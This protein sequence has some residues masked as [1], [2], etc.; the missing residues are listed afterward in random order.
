MCGI[1]P[2]K[3]ERKQRSVLTHLPRINNV[4]NVP[5]KGFASLHWHCA[6]KQRGKKNVMRM[7]WG[8]TQSCTKAV[9]MKFKKLIIYASY[10]K[11]PPSPLVPYYENQVAYMHPTQPQ[12]SL[13]VNHIHWFLLLLQPSKLHMPQYGWE[14]SCVR[15]YTDC[16]CV[17]SCTC[18]GRRGLVA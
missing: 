6:Y 8:R 10:L 5:Q 9:Y 3:V 16:V 1:E 2:Y 12:W 17:R 18:A 4:A 13:I 14:L 7:W 15:A 11:L